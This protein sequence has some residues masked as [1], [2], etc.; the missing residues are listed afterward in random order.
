MLIIFLKDMMLQTFEFNKT[1]I[2]L[3]NLHNILYLS[4]LT[5]FYFYGENYSIT[6]TFF[7]VLTLYYTNLS[8][9]NFGMIARTSKYMSLYLRTSIYNMLFVTLCKLVEFLINRILFYIKKRSCYSKVHLKIRDNLCQ[10]K[11]L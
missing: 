8:V 10:L 1:D 2:I 5:C 7:S 4:F 11:A 6:V 3:V 9:A